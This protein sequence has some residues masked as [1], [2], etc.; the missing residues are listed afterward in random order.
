MSV[1]PQ[2]EAALER[3]HRVDPNGT[4][5]GWL[6]KQKGHQSMMT[7]AANVRNRYYDRRFFC[8]DGTVLRYFKREK[9]ASSPALALGEFHLDSAACQG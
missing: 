2:R 9:D 8:L 3:S 6:I 1:P 7:K 4:H 5:T